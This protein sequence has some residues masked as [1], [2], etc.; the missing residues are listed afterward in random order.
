MKS[1]E[2]ICKNKFKIICK[3]YHITNM[4]FEVEEKSFDLDNITGGRFTSIWKA[5]DWQSIK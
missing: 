1:F 5:V 4:Q 3:S 2:V